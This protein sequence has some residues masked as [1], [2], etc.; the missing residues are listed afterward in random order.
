MGVPLLR[1]LASTPICSGLRSLAEPGSGRCACTR[2]VCM[3]RAHVACACM[4]VCICMLYDF[5]GE[6][7]ISHGDSV[8]CWRLALDGSV[9]VA[10]RA[11]GHTVVTHLTSYSP[12]SLSIGQA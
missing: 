6:A 4:P 2:A 10:G 7:Q 3:H 12:H 8:C 9:V 1:L 5:L 11:S